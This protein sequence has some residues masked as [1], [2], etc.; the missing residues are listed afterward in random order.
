MAATETIAV[1]DFETT[2]IGPNAGARAT[3]IAAVLVR[4]G[5]IVGSYQS[6]MNSGA[7]VPPFIEQL[8]GI[9]N[10][11]LS[12]APPAETV[13]HEVMAF[14]QGCPLVAHNASFDRAFWLAEAQRAECEADDA[15]AFACTVLL[16]RRLYPEASNCR[17]ATLAA[18][19]RLPDAG[20]AH[21]ALADAMTTAQLLMRVQAD[22]A[23]RFEPELAGQPVSH[24]LLAA[25]QRSSKASLKRCVQD[26]AGRKTA[27]LA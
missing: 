8:T 12:T 15:H 14:T 2:G 20:R 17:L 6:L 24:A 18:Y 5:A 7:W 25:L 13:M 4:N 23:D 26:F 9:S 22:V 10:R 19:H 11:M 21:R 1:I 27:V 16:S 3:E